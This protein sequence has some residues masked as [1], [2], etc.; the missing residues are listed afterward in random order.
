MN[1]SIRKYAHVRRFQRTLL[2][3]ILQASTIA[4]LWIG[5]YTTNILEILT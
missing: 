5:L 3:P 2:Y 1:G 4:A